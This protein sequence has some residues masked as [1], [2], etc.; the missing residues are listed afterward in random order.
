MI[1]KA[2]RITPPATILYPGIALFMNN[3]AWRGVFSHLIQRPTIVS[4]SCQL[5]PND[6][7]GNVI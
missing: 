7:T 2:G 3:A 4:M 5:H 1:I 6:G